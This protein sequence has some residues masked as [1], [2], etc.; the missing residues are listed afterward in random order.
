LAQ[1][2][3]SCSGGVADHGAGGLL[4]WMLGQQ[5]AHE[6]PFV[7]EYA[8]ALVPDAVGFDEVGVGAEQGTVLLV[9]GE[10]G[11]AEQGEGLVARA[12]G[13][14]E[15]AMVGAAVGIDQVHPPVGEAFEGAGL[16][17]V[18]YILDDAGDHTVRL[19][20]SLRHERTAVIAARE[21]RA[22]EDRGKAR[23]CAMPVAGA[24][25]DG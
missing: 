9:G 5:R 15:V 3:R 14:Q 19:V 24:G 17:R 22:G 13:W 16:R 20:R 7:A 12:L 2:S 1:I 25:R 23:R 11:E 21:S 8:A 10:A 6:A 4:G 18:D